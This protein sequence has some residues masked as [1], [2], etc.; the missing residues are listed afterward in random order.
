MAQ[1]PNQRISPDAG[2]WH[3]SEIP[4]VFG[5]PDSKSAGPAT[6]DQATLSAFM[7][8]AW[9]EFAKDPENGLE[10]LGLP[11]YDQTGTFS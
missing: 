6:K 1:W 9:A 5:L 7:N 4:S 11:L 3:S 2:A 8:K 10:R